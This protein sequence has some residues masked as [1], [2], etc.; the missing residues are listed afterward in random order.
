MQSPLFMD[1]V[2]MR[3]LNWKI[4]TALLLLPAIYFWCGIQIPL[5]GAVA[6]ATHMA[7]EGQHCDDSCPHPSPLLEKQPE[8]KFAALLTNRSILDIPLVALLPPPYLP[9]EH[10]PPLFYSLSHDLRGP[11]TLIPA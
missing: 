1:I 8:S 2:C 3:V 10:P 6:F 11:P 4:L 9:R 5:G 7:E